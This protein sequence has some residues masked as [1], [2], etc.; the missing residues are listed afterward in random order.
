[1]TPKQLKELQ[2]KGNL[3]GIYL[4]A[5]N[6][7]S[8]V[9]F[10]GEPAAATLQREC[11]RLDGSMQEIV[12]NYQ[13][14]SSGT[15]RQG[16]QH[17][18]FSGQAQQ[19]QQAQIRLRYKEQTLNRIEEETGEYINHLISKFYTE[20]R[21]YRVQD[22]QGPRYGV[23]DIFHLL[24][25]WDPQTNVVTPFTLLM[26]QNP[27]QD[28]MQLKMILESQGQEVYFP[29][30]D[31]QSKASSIMP[32]DRMFNI[33]MAQEL[34]QGK[35]IDAESFFFVMEHGRFEEWEAISQRAQEAQAQAQQQAQQGQPQG[36]QGQQQQQGQPQQQM[37]GQPQHPATD[38]MHQA[39]Q[40]LPPDVKQKLASLPQQQQQQILRSVIPG[41]QNG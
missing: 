40:Q 9:R 28:P 13:V 30:Y 39:I 18:T 15:S 27:D 5:R 31:V 29:E 24:R 21:P 14:Q 25:A 37:Q 1:M 17:P 23:F 34:Y 33:Q 6:P 35:M 8:I 11:D 4:P 36:Q 20:R 19:L 12:G 16:K 22:Q 2:E 10:N 3:P 32:A 41:G 26:A 38:I 7:G